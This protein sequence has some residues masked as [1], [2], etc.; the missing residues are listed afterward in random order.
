MFLCG[1]NSYQPEEGE[2]SDSDEEVEPEDLVLDE[3]FHAETADVDI[4]HAFN[5][6]LENLEQQYF[7][8][9]PLTKKPI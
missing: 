7:R 9:L 1:C 3:I 4:Y 6:V 2:E 5:P 8:K